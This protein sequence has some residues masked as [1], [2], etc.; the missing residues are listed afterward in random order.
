MSSPRLYKHVNNTDVAIEVIKSFYVKEKSIW[1][2]K[3]R[4]YNIVHRPT[5]MGIVE[6][7]KIPRAKWRDEWNLLDT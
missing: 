5:S 3:V 6:T 2:L 1:K 7:I 4:W